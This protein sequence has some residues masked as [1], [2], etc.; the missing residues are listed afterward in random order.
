MHG[1]ITGFTQKV[2]PGNPSFQ[3]KQLILYSSNTQDQVLTF[4]SIV[5]ETK[6]SQLQ[7]SCQTQLPR[8]LNLFGV[9]FLVG[10]QLTDSNQVAESERACFAKCKEIINPA[11]QDLM[12]RLSQCYASKQ[13]GTQYTVFYLSKQYSPA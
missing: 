7:T 11:V 13:I 4:C 2:M 6:Q 5:Y 10:K 9:D 12:G 8:F 3:K 1:W